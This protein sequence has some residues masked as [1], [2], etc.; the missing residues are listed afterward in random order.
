MASLKQKFG[1]KKASIFR[2]GICC[3]MAEKQMEANL[4]ALRA[5]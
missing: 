1:A 5:A 4:P 3:V 2:N